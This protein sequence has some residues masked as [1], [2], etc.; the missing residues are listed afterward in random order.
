MTQEANA[1][2]RKNEAPRSLYEKEMANYRAT[3]GANLEDGLAKYGFALFHCLPGEERF[4]LQKQLGIPCR[5]ASEHYNQG[6]ALAVAEDFAGAVDA[7]KQALKLN[8][9]LNQSLFNIALAQERLGKIAEAKKQ[10]ASYLLTITDEE[11]KQQIEE[12]VAQLG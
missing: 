2:V 5:N 8:P 3:L 1:P 10:Y 4:M 9:S 11:E 7:W 12:H 6:C